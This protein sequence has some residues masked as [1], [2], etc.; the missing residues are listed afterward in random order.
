[1]SISNLFI[2]IFVLLNLNDW[3]NSNSPGEW[4]I[5]KS[6]FILLSIVNQYVMLNLI[7]KLRKC[8]TWRYVNKI[9]FL[10]I[11]Y[12]F[13]RRFTKNYDVM[14]SSIKDAVS[15]PVI[16][17]EDRLRNFEAHELFSMFLMERNDIAFKKAKK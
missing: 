4:I 2:Y 7:L 5:K 14:Y 8:S 10:T 1:M 13:Y 16:T 12:R 6:K 9:E 11:R 3:E 17:P 15:E